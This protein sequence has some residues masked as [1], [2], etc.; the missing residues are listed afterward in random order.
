MVAWL[1]DDTQ[2]MV[3]NPASNTIVTY[4]GVSAL[5]G[6]V[7]IATADTTPVQYMNEID[8]ADTDNDGRA[9]VVYLSG[10]IDGLTTYGLFYFGGTS[11]WD[12]TTGSMQ[13]WLNGEAYTLTTGSLTNYNVITNAAYD[14]HLFAVQLFNGALQ[15]IMEVQNQKHGGQTVNA[16]YDLSASANTSGTILA[17]DDDGTPETGMS[18]AQDAVKN[19][20][21]S[22]TTWPTVNPDELFH[23]GNAH[24]NPY[25]AKTEAVYYLDSAANGLNNDVITFNANGSTLLGSTVQVWRDN[26]SGV[27]NGSVDAGETTIYHLTPNSKVYGIGTGV[28]SGYEALEYLNRTANNKVTI[29]YENEGNSIVGDHQ[30]SIL[31]IYVVTENDITPDTG[32]LAYSVSVPRGIANYGLTVRR[33]RGGL[34][35]AADTNVT[36]SYQLYRCLDVDKTG[37]VAVPAAGVAVATSGTDTI[38]IGA[39]SKTATTDI[40]VAAALPTGYY[41]VRV[42]GISDMPTTANTFDSAVFYHIP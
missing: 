6:D 42:S 2:I 12:G 10:T 15:N 8:W 7:T 22:G 38:S 25:N 1:D 34:A 36:Y 9:D 3:R 5:P 40:A 18:G 20:Q 39:T 29:V 21:L 11:S 26:N 28:T 24:G 27:A 17:I 13:G 37:A 16:L 23:F 35:S 14:G 30:R 31:E 4:D 19:I 33:T 41:F 32:D